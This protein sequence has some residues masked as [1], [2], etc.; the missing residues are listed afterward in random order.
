MKTDALR[1]P[2]LTV[3]RVLLTLG[4]MALAVVYFF[5]R[6]DEFS[7]LDFPSLFAV[8][9]VATAFVFNVTL[10]SLFNLIA[11]RR[12]GTR[13]SHIESFMLSAV[14]TSGNLIL[15]VKL[16][17]GIRALYM[18]KVHGFPVSHF[19]G[20]SFVFMVV[21][22]LLMAVVAFALLCAIFFE[23]D[24]L[25][26]DLLLFFPAIMIVAT[27]TVIKFRARQKTEEVSSQSWFAS[28]RSSI[29]VLVEERSLL[30]A[31]SLIVILIFLSTSVALT[32][33][34]REIAPTVEVLEAFLLAASQIVAG[35]I[36]LTP[37][38]AGFQELVGIYVGSPF[39]ATMTEI[40]AV[41]VWIRVVRILTSLV[42]A[43]PSVWVLRGRLDDT[44][45]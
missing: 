35:F 4:F 24:Y 6:R 9:V 21:N 23:L 39:S 5:A 29:V 45:V 36:T 31:A 41:L 22:F 1:R 26:L 38:A 2:V 13:M 30:L 20:S 42:L 37:G 17:T 16:G 11:A 27:A 12:L 18:K 33:A 44:R 28:L 34:L 25:R 32:V 10:R 7:S 43:V 8:L 15:P 19:V 40:L 3:V 14:V